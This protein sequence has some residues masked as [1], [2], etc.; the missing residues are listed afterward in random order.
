MF[1]KFSMIT[2]D[3][4][5]PI[6]KSNYKNALTRVL[7]AS[8][9]DHSPFN[10]SFLLS[11]SNIQTLLPLPFNQKISKES[12]HFQTFLAIDADQN[13]FTKRK[14][15]TSYLLLFTY[16][17]NGTLLY[18]GQTYMVGPGEGF[19]IDCHKEH[20]YKT[21]G[22]HWYHS[23]LH[24]Q[25]GISDY[26]YSEYAKNN[27]TIFSC[28]V[29]QYQAQLETV[30]K[31]YTLSSPH[32]EF[33]ITESISALLSF[34]LH[35]NEP[36]TNPIPENYQYLIR[37][38]ESNYM[39]NLSLDA[40]SSFANVSKSHL[41]REFKKYTGFSPNDYILELRINHAKFLLENTN[42]PIYS[43]AETVGIPNE[44][45]FMRLFKKRVGITPGA[46]RVSH[47]VDYI[48]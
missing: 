4:S 32:R 20:L 30:L 39:H 6:E 33:F 8:T 18:D 22:K 28:P 36:H 45:N 46:F 14:D 9:I 48:L 24:F 19:L 41:S 17:G 21:S 15:F 40:L 38:I 35:I 44:S 27:C 25:G 43:I 16:D 13:Y 23:D 1:E 34:I 11:G 47:T 5:F 10:A 37:Y 7:S 29:N 31:S 42:F 2:I 12:I 26:L 3:S